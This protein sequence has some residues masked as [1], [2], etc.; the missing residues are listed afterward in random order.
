MESYVSEY[1]TIGGT[2]TTFGKNVC[3]WYD[4]TIRPAKGHNLH[5]RWHFD[6]QVWW[7]ERA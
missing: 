6:G 4:G 3:L 1:G 5:C 7:H 2:M